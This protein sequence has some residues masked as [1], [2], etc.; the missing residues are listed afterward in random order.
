MNTANQEI[1]SNSTPIIEYFGL[2]FHDPE[3]VPPIT[4]FEDDPELQ[5]GIIKI[6]LISSPMIEKHQHILFTIDGSGSMRD[7]CVDGRSKMEHIL[8]TLENILRLFHEKRSNISIHIQSFDDKIKEVVSDVPNIQDANIEELVQKIRT[9]RPRGSTNI[10]LALQNASSHIHHYRDTT[11]HTNYDIVHL[12]LTDGEITQG[13]TNHLALNNIVPTNVTNIF[14]GYGLEHDSHLL[15]VLASSKYNEYR[16]VDALEKAG[17]VYGEIVHS[18]LFKAI[19]EVSIQSEQCEIY[20]YMTNTWTNNL[21]IGNLL[22]EQ[23]K[24][25]HCRTRKQEQTICQ[26]QLKFVKDGAEILVECLVESEFKKLNTYI[27]RQRTQELLYEARKLSEKRRNVQPFGNSSYLYKNT[28]DL[29]HLKRADENNAEIKVLKTVLKDFFKILT[30]YN[31]NTIVTPDDNN[32]IIKMLTDDIYIAHKTLGTKY[33]NM[34]TCARQMTQGRQQ[35]YTCS[36]IDE[37]IDD[38]TAF[39]LPPNVFSSNNIIRSNSNN[40][41]ND[42][43]ANYTVS[44]DV[45][46]PFSSDAAVDLMREI[47]CGPVDDF[48]QLI[49][50]QRAHSDSETP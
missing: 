32:A 38:E 7:K 4:L 31:T 39:T 24:V 16:F 2:E 20:D 49:S 42:L 41:D 46:S 14:I 28:L 33:A 3:I 37:L 9:I 35:I 36:I 48:D 5:F 40:N 1:P 26:V 47:S 19:E 21:F 27:L 11:Q 13:E 12:F 10:E 34:F 15:S 25:Y 17:L 23:K 30:E 22:S 29:N 6:D 45:L 44:Q 43:M 8:H 50:R 18:L